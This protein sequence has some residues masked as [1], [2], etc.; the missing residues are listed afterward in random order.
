MRK[1][2][3]FIVNKRIVIL[4]V[5]LVITAVC[6][7][8]IPKVDINT[9]MT[10]YLPDDSLMKI[11]LDVMEQEFPDEAVT[12]TIRVMF[13]G[14]GA[15]QK[16]DTLNALKQMAYV[17]SVD[18]DADSE[19]YNKGENTLF[20]VHTVYNYGSAEERALE[21]QIKADFAGFN[22]DVVNDD[23]ATADIPLWIVGIAFAI[24][25]TVLFAMCGSW[26]E[27]ILFLV[28]I[29]CAIVINLGT[30]YFMGE[31]SNV[32][33]SVAAI[34]QIVL[35]MDYSIILMN[36]YRQELAIDGEP[37][38]AMQRA[39][40]N[41]FSSIASSSVTTIVGL[42]CLVFMRFKIGFDLGFVLAKGVFFSL[43]CIFTILPGL[44]LLF[45]KLIKKTA[46]KELHIP[47]AGLAM[48]SNRTRYA[49]AAL[50]V[51]L[52]VGS[53]ILQGST[54]TA[55]TLLTNDPI[56]DI[57]PPTNTTVI[58]YE[59]GDDAAVTAIAES[60]EA[61]PAVKTALSYST[62]L[63]KEYCAEELADT[64]SDLDGVDMGI[65]IDATML[66]IL[67]YDYY[68]QGEQLPPITASAF[69]RFLADDVLGNEN[70]VEYVDDSIRENA[71]QL[72]K[73]ADADTLT[74]PMTADTLAAFFEMDADDI[75]KLFLYY[76]TEN[77]GV[78]TGTMTL[79][80]FVDF[81]INDVVTNADYADMLNADALNQIEKLSDFTD[82]QRL[83][84][85][86]GYTAIADLFGMDGDTAKTLFAYYYAKSNGYEPPAM[87]IAEFAA[88]VRQ[89][90]NEPMYA[91]NFDGG[92]LEQIN[93]LS[94]F[95]DKDTIAQQQSAGE[96]ASAFGIDRSM[97]EQLFIF[98]F[99]GE[100]AEGKTMTL[101]QFTAFLADDVL[102]N[103]AYA[104]QFDAEQKQQ[105][106]AL[107]SIVSV[108]ASRRELSAPELAACLGMDES[109]VSQ[110]L[111][112]RFQAADPT[113]LTMPLAEFNA[114]M[115]D[116]VL[117][118]PQFAPYF[119]DADAQQAM[120]LNQITATAA[121]GQSLTAGELGAFLGMDE[122]QVQQLFVLYFGGAAKDRT[123]SQEQFVNYLLSDVLTNPDY[124]A[125]FDPDTQAQLT[126][127][128]NIMTAAKSG[129]K[130]NSQ[131][132]AEL[133]GMDGSDAK[134]LMTMNAPAAETAAWSVSP[135]AIVNF[136]ID[137][138][139]VLGSAMGQSELNDLKTAQ[140]LINGTVSGAEYTETELAALLDMGVSD[141]NG[142]YLLYTSEYGNSSGWK[143]SIQ[144]FVDF[145]ISDVLNNA[146]FADEFDADTAND[147][148]SAQTLIGA[149]VGEREYSA[150]DMVAL[151][152]GLSDEL[153]GGMIELMYLYH[154]AQQGSD[155]AWT[156]SI[157]TLFDYLSSDIVND[158]RFDAMLDGTLR[159][160]IDDMKSDLDAGVS[161]LKGNNY[162]RLIITAEL[163]DE[164]DETTAFLGSLIAESDEKLTGDYY[165]IGSSAMN[166]EMEQSFGSEMTL[167]TIL[168]AVSIFLVVLVT[169]RNIL[170]PTLLVLLVQCGVYITVSVIGLQG[171]GIYYLAL[172]I[173]Q[174]IL[175]GA[176]ID[177][178]ILFTNY[179]RERRRELDVKHALISAYSGSIHTI[180]TSGLIMVLVT[181]VV[182]F[183][184]EDPVVG[185][186]CSTIAIGAL[187]AILL[188]LLVLPGM[189][190]TFDRFVVGKKRK[191]A[192]E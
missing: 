60:L 34:L 36:R 95:T 94:K 166:Y 115:V 170:I 175:M 107:N 171:Y 174:S 176:T 159:A 164:S 35:S 113:G 20:T 149:V 139:A 87:S 156:L 144:R 100:E 80:I 131:K 72:L 148:R 46:K 54:K 129:E 57:F 167:I 119:D 84:T 173:V 114:F 37:K 142:L 27:P 77:G 134:I 71:N 47:T 137:N 58:L 67:Y 141:I 189:L 70:F 32:T 25:L 18:Y 6:G 101:P 184:F 56:A 53:F 160:D 132:L 38:G 125:N 90:A 122:T 191:Q 22:V 127:L 104:G 177:Y 116:S 78:D 76:Y 162:S 185:Q 51:V 23:T 103:E 15:E 44:I 169:F 161:Q 151:L 9:D 45:N 152:G 3:G 187:S 111:M 183:C 136:L 143:L 102:T 192:T 180:L 117:P 55:Y 7:L 105:I 93:K 13:S 79:P 31:V 73:F 146:D 108:A 133:L 10:E 188:I 99:G 63:G 17:D 2:S 82:A 110:L 124:A 42:L 106:I 75:E 21:S 126:T 69:L 59:N 181:G 138:S 81:V 85:R 16:S 168:T 135:Q 172:L 50:F 62:T 74:V 112:M 153:D 147:L 163:P 123:M 128:Q 190:A 11:G 41:A 49:F 5:M 33:F 39:L 66:N 155:P 28:A 121:S 83:T 43:F 165:L 86:A 61:N 120:S 89:S 140:K 14:I 29:G 91:E 30:N 26:A 48:F 92:T 52:F 182:G 1:L 19:D 97:I 68:N 178:G 118:D 96:L 65:N 150:N 98:R 4:T 154:A 130:L 88:A 158:T 109:F 145:V 179:Y 186:I 8:L 12:Q 157:R 40:T 64:L 24:L